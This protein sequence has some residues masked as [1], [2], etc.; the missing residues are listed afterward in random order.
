MT[1]DTLTIYT[2]I[3]TLNFTKF[4]KTFKKL[5]LRKVARAISPNPV[6]EHRMPEIMVDNDPLKVEYGT[7][8]AK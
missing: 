5:L 1:T 8:I 6:I 3:S 2:S 7:K 4:F